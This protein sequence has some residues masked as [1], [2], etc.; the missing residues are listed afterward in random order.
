MKLPAVNTN[1]QLVVYVLKY[2]E[3]NPIP[4]PLPS[5]LLLS[6]RT[7]GVDLGT[8]ITLSDVRVEGRLCGSLEQ[9]D[10]YRYQAT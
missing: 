6:V 9:Q 7:S 2:P 3:S 4:R 8:F 10:E 1:R 5:I